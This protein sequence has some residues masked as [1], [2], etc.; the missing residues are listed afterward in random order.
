MIFLIFVFVIFLLVIL[1]YCLKYFE[2]PRYMNMNRNTWDNAIKLDRKY[3]LVPRVKSKSR[4]VISMTTIPSRLN[5][6]APTLCSILSQTRRVDEIRLNIP[7][8]SRKG[9]KYNIPKCFNKFRYIKIYRTNK[10]YG[11]STKLLPTLKDEK[12]SSIIVIDDDMIYGSDLVRQLVRSFVKHKEKVAITYY[13]CNQKD[14]KMSRTWKFLQGDKYVYLL[15]GCGGYIL[16]GTML[17]D[18]VFDY[19]NGPKEAVF[20]DDNWI[21]GWLWM[22]GVKVYTMG[23]SSNTMYIPNQKTVGTVALCTGVNKNKSNNAIV[24]KWFTQLNQFNQ[25]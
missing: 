12:H 1:I 19:D 5:K 14:D 16:K 3:H 4:V 13:G 23:I 2:I 10:D 22:A 21:S 20:V 9:E 6:I 8:R 11:P 7:Y 24:D 18:E 25:N 17:P 15:F